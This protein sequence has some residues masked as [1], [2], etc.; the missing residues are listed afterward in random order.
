M[1]ERQ[2]L[3]ERLGRQSGPAA[4]QMMQF[5]RAGAGGA[6]DGVG[7]GLVAPVL[8]DVFD[9]AAHDIVVGDPAGQ[10]RQVGQCVRARA[11]KPPFG[12]FLSRPDVMKR[13]PDF[14]LAT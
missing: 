14:C 2:R 4:E 1:I 9:G 10:R 12:C 6:R 3:Q 8:G 13:P 5:G 11:W 7:V